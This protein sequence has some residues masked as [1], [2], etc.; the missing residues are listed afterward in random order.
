MQTF[1]YVPGTG[2]AQLIVHVPGA[3]TKVQDT[4]NVRSSLLNEA[5]T[6]GIVFQ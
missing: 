2:Q 5:Q 3:Q 6:I 4:V 1:S